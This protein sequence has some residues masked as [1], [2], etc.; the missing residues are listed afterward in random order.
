M[1]RYSTTTVIKD[2][3]GKRRAATTIFPIPARSE[4]DI[5]ITVTSDER[6]DTLAH[7]FYKDVQ[8]WWVIAQTNGIGKGTNIVPSGVT[9]RI[10]SVT[11][12]MS[13]VNQR[14]KNR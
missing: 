4:D 11:K 6:L 13:L 2:E 12:I 9:L 3:N 1:S 5:Y 14:N 8:L 7:K 10:P